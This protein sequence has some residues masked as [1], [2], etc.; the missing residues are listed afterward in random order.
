MCLFTYKQIKL[1]LQF[2]GDIYTYIISRQVLNYSHLWLLA[3]I[4]YST[5]VEHFHPSENSLGSTILEKGETTFHYDSHLIFN[6]SFPLEKMKVHSEIL[7]TYFTWLIASHNT[8]QK[9]VKHKSCSLSM[10]WDHKNGFNLTTSLHHI[11]MF[12]RYIVLEKNIV[13]R[14]T[15][16][17]PSLSTS[18]QV[19]TRPATVVVMN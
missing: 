2:L 13:K 5:N 3:T 12:A 19:E 18:A 14:H 4:L 16:L 17:L 9:V 10:C 7:K 8:I 6:F 11:P 1:K 15:I